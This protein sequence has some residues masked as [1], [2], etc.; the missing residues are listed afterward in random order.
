MPWPRIFVGLAIDYLK[1]LGFRYRDVVASEQSGEV[2]LVG[3]RG[4]FSD[5]TAF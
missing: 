5:Q 2:I 4:T 3:A 1:G